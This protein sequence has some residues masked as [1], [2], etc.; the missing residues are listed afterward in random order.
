MAL[1][2]QLKEKQIIAMKAKD[3]VTL[4]TIRLVMSEVKQREVDNKINLSD[5]DILEVLT[6]MM[7][8]R[9]DSLAQYLTANR[10]DLADVEQ[11]E[12]FVI[13]KFMPQPLTEEEILALVDAGLQNTNPT[14]MQDMGKVIAWLKPRIQGRADMANISSLV[15]EKLA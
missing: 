4:G 8:Q 5:N 2:D 14:S 15:R 12:I 1:I 3:K 10:Q 7:K 11:A 13:Q 9:R 6:K